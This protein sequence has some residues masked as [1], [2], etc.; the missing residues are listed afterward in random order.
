M[1]EIE[2]ALLDQHALVVELALG[3]VAH[4]AIDG[5]ELIDVVDFL[6]AHAPAAGRGLDQHHRVGDALLGLE[7]E[8]R[9]GDFL[10]LQLVVDRTVRSRHRGNGQAAGQ[11]LGVDLVTERPDD[12]PGRSDEGQSPGALGH[13]TGETEI[14]GEKAV[15][16][17]DSRG[18][19][20][21]GHGQNFVG[22]MIGAD[23]IG[24]LRSAQGTSQGQMARCLVGLGVDANKI[25]AERNARLDDAHG[26]FAPVGYQDF[27]LRGRHDPSS[28]RPRG[29]RPRPASCA[30]RYAAFEF[31][32]PTCRAKLPDDG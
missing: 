16:R 19:G 2:N 25:Q 18:A 23:P 3:V 10:G 7:G 31:P 4:P 14:L 21:V 6:D 17:M 27:L 30:G 15:A 26:Y 28:S 24:A 29:C 1:I 11:P 9:L 32:G 22:V 20:M 8:Q 12:A 13:P 5:L